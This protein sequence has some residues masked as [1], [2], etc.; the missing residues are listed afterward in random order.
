M[1]HLKVTAL[2]MFFPLF[3][4]SSKNVSFFFFLVFLS[5]TFH[6]CHQYQS[7]TIDVSSVVGAP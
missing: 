5:N 6:C 1:A 4:C 2:F 7:L 3:V